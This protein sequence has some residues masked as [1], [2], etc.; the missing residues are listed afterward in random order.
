MVGN[1]LH[2]IGHALVARPKVGQHLH[3]LHHQARV[4]NGPVNFTLRGALFAIAIPGAL[5]VC[6][7]FSPGCSR[8][9]RIHRIPLLQSGHYTHAD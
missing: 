3:A 2:V 9:L 4:L 7:H 8:N 1:P 6:R 5:Q